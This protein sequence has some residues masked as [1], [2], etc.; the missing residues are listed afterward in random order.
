MTG[1]M[2]MVTQCIPCG[3]SQDKV[4]SHQMCR[5][6]CEYTLACQSSLCSFIKTVNVIGLMEMSLLSVYVIVT[7]AHI[8]LS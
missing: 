4:Q 3:I 1:T 8:F 7:Y 6:L 5:N 2:K